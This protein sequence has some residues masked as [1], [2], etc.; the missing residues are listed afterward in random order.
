MSDAQI[1]IASASNSLFIDGTF[2]IAPEPFYQVI[3][4]TGIVGGN[5]FPIATALLS[6]MLQSTYREILQKLQDVCQENNQPVDFIFIHS[7]CEQAVINAVKEVFPDSQPKLCRFH[8]L[9]AE[10][11]WLDKKGLRTFVNSNVTFRRFYRRSLNIFFFPYHLWP[12]IWELMINQLDAETKA[13]P[14]VENFLDYMVSF[15]Y[16]LLLYYYF[17]AIYKDSS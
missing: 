12:R 11:R 16:L 6:N 3:F 2:S 4:M 1:E 8:I 5:K 14:G 13:F 10:R 15:D 9:D 7:D 17:S